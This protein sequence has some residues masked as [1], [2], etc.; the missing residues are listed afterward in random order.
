M[1]LLLSVDIASGG[2]RIR[3]RRRK[4]VKNWREKE[5]RQWGKA[6]SVGMVQ[7]GSGC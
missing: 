6:V 7:G 3:R 4:K 2:C 1:S 5:R